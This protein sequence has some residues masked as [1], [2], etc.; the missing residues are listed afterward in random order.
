M[1]TPDCVQGCKCKWINGKKGANCEGGR[2]TAVPRALSREVLHLDLRSNHIPHLPSEAF[3]STGLVNLQTLILKDCNISDVHEDAFR[4]LAIL[5]ELDLSRNKIQTLHPGTFRDL[6][7]VRYI[8]LNHNYLM[9]LEAGLFTNLL[10]LQTVEVSHCQLVHIDPRTFVNVTTLSSLKLEGNSLPHIDLSTLE[11][12]ERLRSLELSNNSWRCDC[13]LRPL[14][15]WTMNRTLYTRPTACSEPARLVKKYWDE[16]PAHEFACN[17][18]IVYPS[19]GAIVAVNPELTH[20]NCHVQG[21]PPP[22][23]D[24]VYNHVVLSNHSRNNY[25][26]NSYAQG[27]SRHY[28]VKEGGWANLTIVNLDGNEARGEFK[29]VASNPAGMEERNITLQLGSSGGVSS[30]IGQYG[31]DNWFLLVLLTCAIIILLSLSILLCCCFCRR[32]SSDIE[33]TLAKKSQNGGLSPPNNGEVMHHITASPGDSGK[34]LLTVVNPVQKPPRRYDQDNGSMTAEMTE[35][36]RK[37]L[38]DSTLRDD[39]SRA[40]DSYDDITSSGRRSHNSKYPPDLLAFPTNLRASQPSPAADS[41]TLHHSPPYLYGTLPYNRSQSPCVPLTPQ[42]TAGYVTIPRRPRASWSA[43]PTSLEPPLS[44]TLDPVY[45]SCGVR[46]TVDGSLLS[47]NKIDPAKRALPPTPQSRHSFTLPHKMS[48]LPH[49]YRSSATHTEPHTVIRPLPVMTSPEG[50]MSLQR[51]EP[52]GTRQGG[53]KFQRPPSPNR[54]FTPNRSDRR[55]A[56]WTSRVG[57]PDTSVTGSSDTL[58][59]LSPTGTGRNKFTP[60]SVQPQSPSRQSPLPFTQTARRSPLNLQQ[61]GL[62]PPSPMRKLTPI[63][64]ATPSGLTAHKSAQSIEIL[65]EDE[66]EDGTEV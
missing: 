21:D 3:K 22:R 56:S 5:I 36:N 33:R 23:I 31:T 14:V 20:L 60:I 29:C 53:D 28:V 46:T 64:S 4:G 12:L 57:T 51:M 1:S 13:R 9:K 44:L 35:L 7:K 47:L 52:H 8:V 15:L 43:G 63:P 18:H 6:T 34:S 10:Y 32:R 30:V 59:L 25:A 61:N 62:P 26:H 55:R 37:L 48:T 54:S 58:H 17:P 66:G 24:W 2:F 38:D 41:R 40:G 50:Y 65:F 45:D 11:H 19:P 16:L 42:R 39:E 27:G 49:N